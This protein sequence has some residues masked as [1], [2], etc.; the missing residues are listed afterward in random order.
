MIVSIY[1]QPLAVID[2]TQDDDMEA[3][4]E[5]PE[6][7]PEEV[8]QEWLVIDEL[9]DEDLPEPEEKLK[10][11]EDEMLFPFDHLLCNQDTE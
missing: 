7:M 1:D 11:E 9:Q 5:I 4:D 10:N 8:Q 2:L 6:E 3:P